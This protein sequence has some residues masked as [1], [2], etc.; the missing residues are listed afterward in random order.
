MTITLNVTRTVVDSQFGEVAVQFVNSTERDLDGVSLF[1]TDGG[2]ASESAQGHLAYIPAEEQG[3]YQFATVAAGQTIE[4]TF[5]V[6]PID[7]E[8]GKQYR[9]VAT[10]AW[11]EQQ[12]IASTI[13]DVEARPEVYASI[14]AAEFIREQLLNLYQTAKERGKAAHQDTALPDTKGEPA[15]AALDTETYRWAL[16]MVELGTKMFIDQRVRS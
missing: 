2:P 9:C 11:G 5:A 12:E 14:G 10:A 1:L 16:R 6:K 13:V 8:A 4:R 7:A 15:T 3:G